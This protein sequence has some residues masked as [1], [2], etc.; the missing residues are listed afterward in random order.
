MVNASVND[1]ATLLRCPRHCLNVVAASRGQ[2]A[3]NLLL[4]EGGRTAA[5]DCSDMGAGG[6]AITGDIDALCRAQVVACDAAAILVIEKD[7]TFQH[8]AE[9]RLWD[10]FPSIL[11]TA[12]GFPD[13]ATRMLLRVLHEAMPRI[14]VLGVVDFNPAGCGILLTYRNGGFKDGIG[15]GEG[16]GEGGASAS[17]AA[18]ESEELMRRALGVPVHW[19][20]PLAADLADLPTSAF[21]V[22]GVRRREMLDRLIASSAL[23]GTQGARERAQLMAMSKSGRIAEIQAIDA[24]LGEGALVRMLLRKL[25]RWPHD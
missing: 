15:G 4:R 7:A 3:G 14:P 10:S 8:L 23:A 12:R 24:A 11:I 5:V 9:R 16:G 22:L 20:G 13:V 21:Q 18:N 6:H 19:F 2:V 1:V 25:A 17:T